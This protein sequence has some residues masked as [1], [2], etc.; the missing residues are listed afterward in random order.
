MS[1]TNVGCPMASAPRLQI[2]AGR[3]DSDAAC[4]IRESQGARDVE[5]AL[6][7]GDGPAMAP[8]VVVGRP[9]T[10]PAEGVPVGGES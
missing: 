6:P 7:S 3:F 10:Y 8:G 5:I 4:H 2:E 9:E 1:G